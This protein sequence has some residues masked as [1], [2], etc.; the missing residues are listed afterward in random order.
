LFSGSKGVLDLTRKA[1]IPKKFASNIKA[2]KKTYGLNLP[3]LLK[4]EEHAILNKISQ[5]K[6]KESLYAVIKDV[7]PFTKGSALPY[8]KQAVQKLQVYHY[9]TTCI[10]IH[11]F[12][13]RCYLYNDGL[14]KN[15][16]WNED[17]YRI[18]VYGDLFDYIF[19]SEEGYMTKRYFIIAY[20]L[21]LC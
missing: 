6:S 4:K 8:I 21:F 20:M 7:Y 16:D 18:M 9:L 15:H 14:L 3:Y 2:L 11:I 17:W 12:F 13:L 10:I 5:C 1:C 19:A